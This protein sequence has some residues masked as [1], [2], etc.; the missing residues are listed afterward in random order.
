MLNEEGHV[1]EEGKSYNVSDV[2]SKCSS[3]KVIA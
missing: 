2:V 3:V 1:I